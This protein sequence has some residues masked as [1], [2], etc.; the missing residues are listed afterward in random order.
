MYIYIQVVKLNSFLIKILYYFLKFN[1][2]LN[3]MNN[4]LKILI[5]LVFLIISWVDVIAQVNQEWFARYNGISNG[6]DE[7]Y[8]VSVDNLGS[9]IVTGRSFDSVSNYDYATVKYNSSGN[10]AWVKRYNGS[11]NGNDQAASVAVDVT[12]YDYTTIK[13]SQ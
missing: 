12:N 11:A 7:A 8:S 10:Q 3:I 9:V 5:F 4:L 2:K 13:Y 1:I 6:N